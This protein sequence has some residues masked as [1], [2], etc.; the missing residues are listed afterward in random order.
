MDEEI[1]LEVKRALVEQR[2]IIWRNTV[3][4]STVDLKVATRFHDTDLITVA[5][6]SITKAEQMI[7]GYTAE[8]EALRN[9]EMAP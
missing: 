6:A 1:T 9:G 7:A 8:L 3:F 2:I 5:K 4:Q